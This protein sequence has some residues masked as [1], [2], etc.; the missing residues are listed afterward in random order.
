MT[1]LRA[2][3]ARLEIQITAARKDLEAKQKIVDDLER[4]LAEAKITRDSARD[5]LNKLIAQR[6]GILPRIDAFVAQLAEL[7]QKLAAC[8]SQ[9]A[10][11]QAR[12]DELLQSA[13][14]LQKA[15]DEVNAIIT[16]YQRELDKNA[17]RIGEIDGILPTLNNNKTSSGDDLTY[18]REQLTIAQEQLRKAHQAGNDANTAVLFAQQNLDAATQRYNK[19][20]QNVS[21]ATLNL[22]KARAEE[23]LARLALEETIAHYTDALPYA[24][25]PNGNGQTPAG[26]PYGN[27]PSGSPLGPVNTNT[28]GAPGSFVI[29]DWT[30]YLSQA[31]GAGVHPA[32]TGSVNKIYPFNFFST[33]SGK[34]VNNNYNG[35]RTTGST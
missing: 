24:I 11:I 28:D 31:F 3:V 29:N 15:I 1:N 21:T 32:F 33:V 34:T 25:V 6:D 17:G 4:R 12:I 35:L 13:A 14:N 5:N 23:A 30:H 22:E 10:Q 26:T 27:N 16:G 19:E 2:Q 7:K 20:S 18:L 9:A 8:E